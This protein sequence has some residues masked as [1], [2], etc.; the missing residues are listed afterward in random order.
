MLSPDCRQQ[1]QQKEVQRLQLNQ[2][3]RRSQRT[4]SRLLKAGGSSARVAPSVSAVGGD[5]ATS[6]MTTGSDACGGDEACSASTGSRFQVHARCM[7]ACSCQVT[8]RCSTSSTAA[9]LATDLAY[10]RMQGAFGSHHDPQ[11]QLHQLQCYVSELQEDLVSRQEA[12][13]AA[14]ARK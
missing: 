10:P 5:G 13:G 3:L 11:L 14:E 6:G 2:Q 8:Q 1:L 4:A 12:V 9:A 7:H